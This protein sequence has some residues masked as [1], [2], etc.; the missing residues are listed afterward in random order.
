MRATGKLV[1]LAA[2]VL[3]LTP[4]GVAGQSADKVFGSWR[5]SC[6]KQDVKSCFIWH[7]VLA[8]PSNKR[9]VVLGLSVRFNQ[10]PTVPEL[11][12]RLTPHADS[13]AGVGLKIDNHP[14]YK[15]VMSTCD[16]RVCEANGRVQGT[17][18]DQMVSGKLG[19]LAYMESGK[20]QTV[21]VALNG[22]GAALQA[23]EKLQP[24]KAK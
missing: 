17:V 3:A 18:R 5:L 15:L 4:L 12:I 20:Q 24:K 7:S 8:D 11:Q 10:S 6:P 16:A 13:R 1:A 21:I 14:E 2:F 19:Q 9:T 23:L 22:F